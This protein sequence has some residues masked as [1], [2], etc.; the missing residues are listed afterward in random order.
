MDILGI[1][2]GMNPI[3]YFRVGAALFVF[4]GIFVGLTAQAIRN[5]RSG[6]TQMPLVLNSSLMLASFCR[7]VFF[8]LSGEYLLMLVDFYG[9]AM[10]A[11]LA[12]QTFGLFLKPQT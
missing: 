6:Q 5:Y 11:I 3:D 8:L 7:A 10:S 1:I 12:S 4:I 2:R 9:F